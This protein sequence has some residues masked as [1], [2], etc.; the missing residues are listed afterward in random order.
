MVEHYLTSG[1]RIGWA[2]AGV[3]RPAPEASGWPGRSTDANSM[4]ATIAK[5]NIASTAV[6]ARYGARA[7]S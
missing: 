3:A 7:R 2:G 5:M 1:A 4:P 6:A